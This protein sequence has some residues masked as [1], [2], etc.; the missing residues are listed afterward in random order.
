MIPVNTWTNC[1]WPLAPHIRKPLC[2][3]LQYGVKVGDALEG[4]EWEQRKGSLLQ[5]LWR[6]LTH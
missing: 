6:A 1:G 3:Q 5:E 2:Q 4:P